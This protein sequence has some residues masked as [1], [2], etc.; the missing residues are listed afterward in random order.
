MLPTE[1]HCWSPHWYLQLVMSSGQSDGWFCQGCF[2][3]TTTV[4]Q[5]GP[6]IRAMTASS[7]QA[8][9]W[10]GCVIP[11]CS[12]GFWKHFESLPASKDLANIIYYSDCYRTAMANAHLDFTDKKF[13]SVE[14]AEFF[15]GP[16]CITFQLRQDWHV[17]IYYGL[18]FPGLPRG[19][20]SPL[21]GVSKASIS[22]PELKEPWQWWYHA[23]YHV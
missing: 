23:T 10:F 9:S 22:I 19:W 2:T 1:L 6:S 4:S 11:Q 18:K 21:P 5:S 20:S 8:M 3:A 13:L 12:Q 14:A 17:S 7:L 16:L 15:S